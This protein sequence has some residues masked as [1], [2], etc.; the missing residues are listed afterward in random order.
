MAALAPADLDSIPRL[1]WIREASPVTPLP[2]LA[3]ALGL[4]YFGVKRDD[5][6]DALHGGAKRRKLDYLLAT[7]PFSEAKSWISVGGIGSG[8]LVALSLAAKELGRRLQAHVFWTAI[9]DGILDN[10]AVTA[11]GPTS[12]SFHASRLTLALSRPALVLA[13]A[14]GGV[15]I[16]PPG[17]TSPIGMIGIVR[18]GLELGVQ[19][20]DGVLPAPDRIYVALGSGGTAVGLAM[21]LALAGVAT[22][23]A[24]TTV[25]ERILASNA[26]VHALERTL[27]DELQRWGIAPPPLPLRIAIDRTH[28]GRGYAEPTTEGLDACEELGRLGIGIEPVYTGKAMAALLADAR[29][30]GFKR[31]LFW[32][33]ARRHDVTP[34]PAWRERLPKAL[35]RRIDPGGSTLT[36]R[37]FFLVSSTVVAGA[38]GLRVTGYA[39]LPGFRGEVLALWEAHVIRAAAEALLT[40]AATPAQIA[41]I[42]TLVDRFLVALPAATR[43]EVH[44]LLALVEHGS[45]PLAGHVSRFT[46]LS[47]EARDACLAKL[48]AHG[49]LLEQ[50]HRGLRDLCMLGLYQQ[51]STWAAIGYD[52]PRQTLD[53]N[54]QGPDRWMWASYDALVA[55]KQALPRGVV[56]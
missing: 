20:R 47:V 12:L 48:E 16:V 38:V 28:L 23:V 19:I 1:G 42:P 53:Y 39:T 6:L 22:T 25:V 9:T 52:G 50:A 4:E 30:G 51:P 46:G 26:R 40:T 37:R 29:R 32:Q 33:T 54:P 56:R 34:D 7:P 27:F 2:D 55:P 13:H 43:R 35:R 31:V 18:A 8:A 14:V 10:L 11:S 24:A 44:E 36:R 5:C 15:P 49:G 17:A 41:A 3:K 45:A 21:G